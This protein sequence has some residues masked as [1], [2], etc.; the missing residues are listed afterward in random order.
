MRVGLGL[1][2]FVEYALAGGAATWL[3]DRADKLVY[4]LQ[5]EAVHKRGA[6]VED[7]TGPGQLARRVIRAAAHEPS[8][9]EAVASV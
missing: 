6:A 3:M 8:H 9:D 4:Q 2:P 7:L 5:S 1:I